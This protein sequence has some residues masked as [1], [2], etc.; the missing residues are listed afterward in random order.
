MNNDVMS[1]NGKIIPACEATI[2]LRSVTIKYAASVFEGIRGYK[3]ERGGINIFALDQHI[4]RLFRSMA[5]MGFSHELSPQ[6]VKKW[7]LELWQEKKLD[8]DFYIR[9]AASVSGQGGVDCSTPILLSIDASFKGRHP[10]HKTGAKLGIS[11]WRRVCEE[12]LPAQIK[13]IANYQNARLA[14]LEAKSRHVDLPLFLTQSGTISESA[15]ASIF[16]IRNGKIIT[17]PLTADLLESITREFLFQLLSDN[18]YEIE[19][20]EV[21]RM[22]ACFADEAFLLGTGA[23]VIPVISIDSYVL[24]GGKNVTEKVRKMYFSTIRNK[25][26]EYSK[27]FSL[28]QGENYDG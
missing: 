15:T 3:M 4:D 17:P 23:E 16:F 28:I 10:L 25:N 22:E 6:L 5:A 8:D 14:M 11:S 2:S 19:V 21:S 18:G 24:P 12:S 1:L 27:Y 13:C 20:R 9:C 7:I 26:P